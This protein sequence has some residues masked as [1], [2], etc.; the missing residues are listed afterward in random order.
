MAPGENSPGAFAFIRLIMR[1]TFGIM[2]IDFTQTGSHGKDGVCMYKSITQIHNE[3]DGQWVF[4]INCD[5]NDYGSIA[6]GEVVLHSENRDV[7][8]RKMETYDYEQS[9][10]SVRYAGNI[11]EGVSLL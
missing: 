1:I 9:L 2:K 5:K 7:V 11:P 10:T 4:M 6:G 8:F 3:Y